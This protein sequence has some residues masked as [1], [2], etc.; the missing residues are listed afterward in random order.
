MQAHK[1]NTLCS[2]NSA[3][4]T[5]WMIPGLSNVVLFVVVVGGGFF[6][7]PLQRWGGGR[8]AIEFVKWFKFWSLL[9]Q[10][11]LLLMMIKWTSI[12]FCKIRFPCKKLVHNVKYNKKRLFPSQEDIPELLITF[13]TV[14]D[15]QN[16]ILIKINIY[17]YIIR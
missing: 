3:H 12:H 13:G 5:L 17:V 16:N 9:I 11:S 10:C 14:S 8:C 2:V 7:L 15:N 1:L 6:I 4:V